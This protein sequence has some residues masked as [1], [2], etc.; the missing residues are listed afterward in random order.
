LAEPLLAFK[1]DELHRQG[2]QQPT[3]SPHAS[4]GDRS[5]FCCR[6]CRST[7]ACV[8]ALLPA[9]TPLVFANPLGLVFELVLVTKA[10]SL[11]YIGALTTEHTWFSGYAWQVALCAGCT[12]HLGWRYEAAEADR[13]PQL[14]YGLLR[15]ELVE[16]RAPSDR[17]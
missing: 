8:D 16:L 6:T 17:A 5:F 4:A 15:R 7:I 3:S 1:E 13:S 12:T 10:D 11:V 14:F 9:D 2:A